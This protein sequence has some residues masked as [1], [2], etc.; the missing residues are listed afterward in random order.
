MVTVHFAAT[1]QAITVE[2]RAR[3]AVPHEMFHHDEQRVRLKAIAARVTAVG[4]LGSEPLAEMDVH[5]ID[6]GLTAAAAAAGCIVVAAARDRIR[7]S[8]SSEEGDIGRHNNS[9]GGGIGIISICCCG[10]AVSFAC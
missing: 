7:R 1:V 10:C 2:R 6:G 9:S 5:R 4:L 8:S 3:R